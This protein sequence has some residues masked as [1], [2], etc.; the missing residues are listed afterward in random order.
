MW[1]IN[2]SSDRDTLTADT[3]NVAKTTGLAAVL[4]SLGAPVVSILTG[5]EANDRAV[6]ITLIG[7]T[8]VVLAAAAIAWAIVAA[9]DLRARA[10]GEAA[11]AAASGARDS[12]VMSKLRQAGVGVDRCLKMLANTPSSPSFGTVLAEVRAHLAVARD[13]SDDSSALAECETM[14]NG[15][16]DA[17]PLDL[18]DEVVL[19][20]TKETLTA[21]K[22]NILRATVSLTKI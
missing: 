5:I 10:A 22:I 12:T 17:M 7:A 8:A 13:Q 4:T 20:A 11:K 15:L 14:A 18:D 19:Q 3:T 21:L 6:Q 1:L 2:K 9:A 16:I